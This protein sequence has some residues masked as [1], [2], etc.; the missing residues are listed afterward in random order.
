MTHTGGGGPEIRT[1]R[2][3]VRALAGAGLVVALSACSTLDALNP[4]SSSPKVKMAE[5][6]PIAGG[7]TLA[8]RWQ[9]RVGDAGSHVFSPAVVGSS[10]YAAS[11]DGT[12]VRFDDGR[13]RWRISVGRA[14]SGGVGADGKRIVVGTPKG[15]VLA[16]DGEGRPVWTAR[17]SSEVL[18]APAVGPEI[19]IV[20][21]GDNRLFALDATDGKRRWVY[22]R[23]TPPLTLRSPAGVTLAEG[24][25]LAGFPGGKLVAVSIANGAALWEATVAAPKGAT[26]LER[27]ADVA[28]P[29]LVIAGQVCA[30]AFQGKVACFDAASAAPSWSRDLSSIAGI[31]ADETR[32]YVTDDRGALHALDRQTGAPVWRND[33]LFLREV[34]RA[35]PIAGHVA[36]GDVKGYV[37]VLRAA[38]GSFAARLAT[39]GTAIH[40]APVPVEGGFLVQTSGGTLAAIAL[41]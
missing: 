35:L 30:A 7:A 1:G 23:E 8:V 15:E 22:Q 20:R 5:L 4:F 26:E 33:K 39:D 40:A 27:V 32:L 14:L 34:T 24:A 28:S 16:F 6:E 36:V 41:P 18:A 13:E 21:S 25:V 11:A 3:L 9:A 29:P 19:V 2:R 17:V 12:L 31:A 38:D 10:V 37:H